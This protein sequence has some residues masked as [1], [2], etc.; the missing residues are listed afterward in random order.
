[1]VYKYCL[2]AVK[3]N[4][5]LYY[6]D[7]GFD[8]EEGDRVIIPYGR[9]N[10]E[11]EGR[12]ICINYYFD[13]NSVPFPVDKT[14]AIIR[15]VEV[16]DRKEPIDLDSI[17][18]I[19]YKNE[20]EILDVVNELEKYDTLPLVTRLAYLKHY[21]YS[22]EFRRLEK[23]LSYE[24]VKRFE[25]QYNIE[26]PLD[27]CDFIIEVGNG[28]YDIMPGI[29]TKE[30]KKEYEDLSKEP[31][32][33]KEEKFQD[34]RL[35]MLPLYN[36]YDHY[37]DFLVVTGENKG[38]I[39]TDG[40]HRGEFDGLTFTE[41]INKIVN[42]EI[43]TLIRE[44]KIRYNVLSIEKEQKKSS[45]NLFKYCL[46]SGLKDY[47]T[48]YYIDAG[49]NVEVGDEV[50]VEWG[51]YGVCKYGTVSA[52][53]YYTEDKVPYPIRKTKMI[54]RKNE[55]D[56][57]RKSGRYKAP[58]VDLDLIPIIKYNNKNCIPSILSALSDLKK[59]P[60]FTKL[61]YIKHLSKDHRDGI[62][63]PPIDER[64]V[65][66][67]EKNFGI[68]LPEE[69]RNFI[70]NVGN[71]ISGIA[72]GIKVHEY[73]PEYGF[74][75]CDFQYEEDFK[76]DCDVP[77]WDGDCEECPGYKTCKSACWVDGYDYQNFNYKDYQ[78]GSLFLV[79]DGCTYSDRL[80]VSGKMRGS[81][82]DD[83]EEGM[84]KMSDS[85]K[86]YVDMKCDYLLYY[87]IENLKYELK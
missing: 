56:F 19:I 38:T 32:V 29:N 39:W 35:G 43:K 3:K 49:V 62:L 65:E 58:V 80:V 79:Y 34:Y 83:N 12:V 5:Q 2:V 63:Y 87:L 68:R 61:A 7:N 71:G 13:E 31:C 27:F 9:D 20:Q 42:D 26:L 52:I 22:W 48:F 25:K 41:Y 15:K 37:S 60:L 72:H 50:I 17:P 51:Y 77:D 86:S 75:A 73:D 59:L 33:D 11:K 70:I 23:C 46:V 24:E 69:Y 54:M 16:L 21:A 66:Q 78:K 36:Y 4:S 74:L 85:F 30:Y 76:V 47:K 8:V 53:E 6:L 57:S 28:I 84:R 40:R 1:M 18:I 14:K 81:V 55:F 64:N 44:L 82:W 10:I 45:N 67:F